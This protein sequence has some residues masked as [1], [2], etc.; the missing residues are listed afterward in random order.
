MSNSFARNS[1]THVGPATLSSRVNEDERALH[2]LLMELAATWNRGDSAAYA[3]LFTPDCDYIAFDGRH[4]KGARANEDSHRALFDTVLKGSELVYENDIGIRFVGPA[5]AVL[6]AK[7]CVRLAFQKKLPANRRSIQTYVAVRDAGIWRI[8][9]F[10]NTRIQPQ[11]LP[12]GW[13]LR[14]LMLTLRTKGALGNL[15]GSR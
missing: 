9:A 11:E 14:L 12:T 10:Q 4:L 15:F 6:H 2:A 8:A 13:K 1:L 5:A 7:G 3:R